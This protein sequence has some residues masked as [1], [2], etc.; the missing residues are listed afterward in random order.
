METAVKDQER[1][2]AEPE[3]ESTTRLKRANGT[4]DE[5]ERVL[6]G[7]NKYK[8]ISSLNK[9]VDTAF[10]DLLKKSRK[11]YDLGKLPREEYVYIIESAVEKAHDQHTDLD[12]TTSA[13]AISAK[14]NSVP[15]DVLREALSMLAETK[16]LNE[17]KAV[18][19][20]IDKNNPKRPL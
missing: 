3:K 13:E 4:G 8:N 17:L 7:H 5:I 14:L 10:A 12:Q 9:D 6:S 18:V 16:P 20:G 1:I 19:Q 11:A 2:F 15:E